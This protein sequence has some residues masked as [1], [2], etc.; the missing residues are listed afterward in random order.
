[1]IHKNEFLPFLKNILVFQ[2]KGQNFDFT[3]YPKHVDLAKNCWEMMLV[4]KIFALDFNA[5]YLLTTSS[6]LLTRFFWWFDQ[7]CVKS[8]NICNGWHKPLEN[9][10]PS[11]WQNQNNIVCHGI[12][13][14][15][16]D[17]F[18]TTSIMQI[19]FICRKNFKDIH[20]TLYINDWFDWKYPSF[21]ESEGHFVFKIILSSKANF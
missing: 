11:W 9:L 15:K 5:R 1:M 21:S 19:K 3:K 10:D 13:L 14:R 18:L 16:K 12:F 7:Y 17:T 20:A 2:K 8:T 4:L 6:C